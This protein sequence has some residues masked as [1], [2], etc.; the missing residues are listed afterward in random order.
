M[1]SRLV[2]LGLLIVVLSG[3]VAI[4]LQPGETPA[5]TSLSA[6]TPLFPR[7]PPAANVTVVRLDFSNSSQAILATSLQGIVNARA[8]RLYLERDPPTEIDSRLL[9]LLV[10]RHGVVAMNSSLESALQRFAPEISGLIIYDPSMPESVN[11]GTTLSGLRKGLLVSPAQ[12]TAYGSSLGLPILEDLRNPPW[13]GLTGIGFYRTALERLLPSVNTS[14]VGYLRPDRV[15]P[16]D[17]LIAA[18]SFVFYADA[19]PLASSEEIGLLREVLGATPANVAMMGWVRTTTG[20]EENFLIQETSR[21][22]KIFVGG[23]DVPNLSLLSAFP[24]AG[25][26]RQSRPSGPRSLEDKVY[27]SFAIPDGDNLD[28]VRGRMNDLW[29]QPA[30]GAV[31]IGWSI[32]PALAEIAPAYLE[33]LYADATSNDTFIAGPSGVGYVFPGL[34]PETALPAFLA[35]TSTAMRAA[36]LRISWLLNTYRASEVPYPQRV[37]DAYATNVAPAGLLLDYGDRPT[38]LS[39]WAVRGTPA[40]RSFHYWSSL[41]N[42]E[43]KVRI[44]LESRGGAQFLVVALYPFTK[45]LADLRRAVDAIAALAPGRVELVPI[46]NL[47]SLLGLWLQG[48]APGGTPALAGDSLVLLAA[49]SFIPA[50]GIAASI[51]ANRTRVR[52]L[53]RSYVARPIAISALAGFSLTGLLVS[54]SI[55]VVDA[56]FW[57]LVG[58]A[59]AVAAIA[60]LLVIP[61]RWALPE[62]VNGIV[63]VVALATGVASLTWSTW[64]LVPLA[65]G[66]ALLT[67]RVRRSVAFN[68]AA[69]FVSSGLGVGAAL[70]TGWNPWIATAFLAAGV[71]GSLPLSSREDHTRSSSSRLA[72]AA[73]SLVAVLPLAALLIPW[74]AF[75]SSRLE[76]NVAVLVPAAILALGLAPALG[77]ALFAMRRTRW[78]HLSG[79]GILVLAVANV[80]GGPALLSA[81]V[82]GTALLAGVSLR[83]SESREGSP[84]HDGVAATGLTMTFVALARIQPVYY[85]VYVW[86]GPRTVEYALYHPLVTV[87]FV[88]ALSALAILLGRDATR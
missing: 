78:R 39:S 19:G 30:R 71:L 11:V 80:L 69:W 50:I 88:A 49:E 82:L 1:D 53:A 74:T 43:E 3:V 42:L 47:F 12:A 64:G 18:R 24:P 84:S 14:I 40:T 73:S 79:S 38:G 87:A 17:Y 72:T 28:F 44:E 61:R 4:G 70:L 5:P 21:A 31:P 41:E 15:G 32:S 8:A 9:G 25:P 37:L 59:A 57:D 34:F 6:R 83:R 54:G 35:E 16:R 62:S 36:D 60:M 20:A 27:I 48:R 51:F 75:F 26:L 22:G 45:N 29:R 33:L 13:R 23:E 85:S 56:N 2:G 68:D 7:F 77:V 65:I 81:M 58:I 67:R 52:A 55:R 76:G 46:E 63:A 10:S 86:A 66:T